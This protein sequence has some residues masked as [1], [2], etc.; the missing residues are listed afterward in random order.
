VLSALASW[1]QVTHCSAE[2]PLPAGPR[3]TLAKCRC[4]SSLCCG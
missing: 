4:R 1:W 2:T 3:T